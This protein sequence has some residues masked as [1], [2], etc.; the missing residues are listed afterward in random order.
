MRWVVPR[1]S[2]LVG[3]APVAVVVPPVIGTGSAIVLEA[4]EPNV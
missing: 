4:Q 2:I 3:C 1:F